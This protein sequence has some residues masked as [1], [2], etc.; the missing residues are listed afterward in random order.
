MN[1]QG[2]VKRRQRLERILKPI[3]SLTEFTTKDICNVCEEE[4]PTFITKVLNQLAEQ[5]F[6]ARDSQRN[7]K[8]FRWNEKRE[9]FS[10]NSWIESQ[11]AGKQIM[12]APSEDRP[13]ERLLN[14]GA[15]K[16]RTAELLAILIRVGRQGESA[17]DAGE[18]VANRYSEQLGGL[19]DCSLVEIKGV[20]QAV[21]SAAY[22]QIMAGIE[23]GRRVV[24]SLEPR[25]DL[26]EKITSTAEAISYCRRRFARLAVDRRQEEFHVVSL[27]TKLFPIGH[28]QITV[29]T[30]NA[31]LVHPREVFRAAI[32]DAASAII[33]V[34][35]H[36]S[37]DPTPSRED[38]QVTDRLKKAADI[39]GIKI[40]DH[41]VVAS[42]SCVSIAEWQIR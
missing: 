21:S 32:R 35:N 30:L 13:R 25:D 37:G 26:P 39:I 1:R 14:L 9:S 27:D 38:I 20:S 41:I 23:L 6:L 28:H 12:A 16:L 34:H 8:S 10:Q 4:T 5:G 7:V 18:K 2:Q 24:E 11:V 31:S 3:C 19:R 33:L 29:G 40:L 15:D 17:L 22:C 36:P 42:Q